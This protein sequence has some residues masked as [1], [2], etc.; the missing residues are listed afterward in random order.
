MDDDAG[1]IPQTPTGVLGR[2]TARFLAPVIMFRLPCLGLILTRAPD[3]AEAEEIVNL[4]ARFPDR[5]FPCGP[6]PR[7][8]G[9]GGMVRGQRPFAT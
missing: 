2:V 4:T 5:A 9:R 3:D 7:V 6:R 8:T 1:L